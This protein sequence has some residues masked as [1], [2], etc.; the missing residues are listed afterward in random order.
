MKILLHSS[1]TMKPEQSAVHPLTIP[2]FLPQA[3]FINNVLQ[4]LDM[5]ELEKLMHIH[6][7]LVERTRDTIHGWHLNPG[8]T[9]AALTFRGDIY[10]GLSAIKWTKADAEFAQKHLLILSGLYGILR[11]FDQI[12]PYRLEM[13]Y[14]L[15]LSKNLKLEQYWEAELAG[16]LDK[17]D[18]Y[19]NLTANEY[20]K[21]VKKQ[22]VTS[23]VI[24][25]KFLTLSKKTN[26]P[27]FVTVHAKIAR[28]SFANWL[29]V[30][31][32]NKLGDITAYDQLN[33]VYDKKLSTPAE[34]VFVCQEFGG[35][36]LS[37]RLK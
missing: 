26:Q 12:K 3:T 23:T 32:I 13:G 25:P 16:H 31:H 22:L 19:I 34:P 11:P 18:I 10:S 35:L 33:Y 28:G 5:P 21:V 6:D 29:I 8:G 7:S 17:N 37:V 4:H 24:T 36:G 1:K 9:A 2:Q 15:P 14:K 30:N 27:V 20:Y